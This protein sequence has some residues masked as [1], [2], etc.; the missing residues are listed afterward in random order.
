MPDDMIGDFVS[1]LISCDAEVAM[2]SVDI[3]RSVV[4]R[5]SH[6]RGGGL[7]FFLAHLERPLPTLVSAQTLIYCH[8]RG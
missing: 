3:R 7:E 8:R 2:T 4:A 5:R 1:K 6:S